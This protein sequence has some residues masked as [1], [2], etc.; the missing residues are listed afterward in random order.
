MN[1]AQLGET[2]FEGSGGRCG[3][4]G[5][6]LFGGNLS[7]K[8]GLDDLCRAKLSLKILGKIREIFALGGIQ[9]PQ[10]FAKFFL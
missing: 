10:Q 2:F 3:F 6:L 8:V 9:L 1:A 5:G 7:V 4:A